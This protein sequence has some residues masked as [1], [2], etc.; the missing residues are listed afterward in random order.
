MLAAALWVVL[1][2]APTENAAA[3]A[4]AQALLSQGAE[5]YEQ[6][7]YAAALERF[8]AAYEVFPSPKLWFNIGQANRDLGRPV[9]ALEA[10]E[11]FLSEAPA[12]LPEAVAEA[13]RSATDLAGKLGQLR[14]TCSTPGAE[15]AVDGRRVGT[16][17]PARTVW[18]TPGRHQVTVRHSGFLPAIEDAEVT[19]GGTRSVTIEL[20]ALAPPPGDPA[21]SSAERRESAD[22]T[23][24]RAAPLYR[25]AWFWVAVGAVVA[26]GGVTIAL[27]A[28][29]GTDIPHT[30]LGPAKPFGD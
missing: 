15:V 29:P 6:G 4:E 10:F 19:A 13:R 18:T 26:A 9:E 5:L 3:K 2:I 28:F 11:R 16:V 17:P 21:L 7:N 14:V 22:D 20:R 12:A 1:A 25:R 24:T 23:E 30:D 8:T 27:L